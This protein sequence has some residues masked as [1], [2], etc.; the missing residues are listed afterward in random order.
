MFKGSSFRIT[1]FAETWNR[2]DSEY[3]M[4]TNYLHVWR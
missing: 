2:T 3:A 1:A 4:G